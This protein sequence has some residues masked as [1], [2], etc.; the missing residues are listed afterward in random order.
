[1]CCALSDT[2]H[3]PHLTAIGDCFAENL[4]FHNGRPLAAVVIF[5]SCL[6]WK[7]FQADRTTLFDRII[8]TMGAQ[9]ERQQ[10]DNAC[11]AYWLSNTVTLLYMLQRNIKPASGGSYYSSRIRSPATRWA[12]L[13]QMP[14]KLAAWHQYLCLFLEQHLSCHSVFGRGV[15]S[16]CQCNM[17]IQQ[18]ICCDAS[19]FF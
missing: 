4:G 3:L 1:M 6:Q 15:C 5:R 7:T 8:N 18:W 2:H 12:P 16:S 10:E 13:S 14:S 11:L 17:L 9:L 19:Y